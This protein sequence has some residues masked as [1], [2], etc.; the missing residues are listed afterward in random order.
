LL[1]VGARFLGALAPVLGIIE[2]TVGHDTPYAA[3][4]FAPVRIHPSMARC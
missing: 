1:R 2:A 4:R 3:L